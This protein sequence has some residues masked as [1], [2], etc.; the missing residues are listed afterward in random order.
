MGIESNWGNGV[1]DTN[2]PFPLVRRG[3]VRDVYETPGGLLIVA[4]DRLSAFDA[5]FPDPIPGK[6]RIL[7]QLSTWWLQHTQ[8]I[9]EN[10]IID[11]FPTQLGL[12]SELARVLYGRAA[13]CRR[14]KVFPVECVVRG[15]LEGS[16]LTAY[17]ESQSVCGVR[18]P[19]GIK[20]GEKLAFPIFTPTTKEESG[21]DVPISFEDVV[22][23]I[24]HEFAE[25][26]RFK[27]LQLF[28]FAHDLLLPKGIILSDTK[29]EFGLVD[30]R[31][32]LVDEALTPDSSRFW[33]AESYGPDS[34]APR[35]F[36]KQYV[37]DYVEATGWNKQPPAPRLPEEVILGTMAR[38]EEIFKITTGA[39]IQVKEVIPQ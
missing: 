25:M 32:V 20:R 12:P 13:L 6:G 21:H 8:E 31:V 11:P 34:K 27:S 30:D 37:R 7:H 36:D 14:A 15:Y 10:H 24:G 16:A 17:K 39:E 23:T 22:R 3:K 2:L 18:L 28:Q 4:T 33:E 5:V 35:S 26:I 38:Y 9:S 29:F 19:V 1:K